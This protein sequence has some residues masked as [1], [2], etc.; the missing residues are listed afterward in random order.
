[1]AEAGLVGI[2]LP[3]ADGGSGFGVVELCLVAE[4]VGR[5]VAPVPYVVAAC[6][7]RLVAA[8]G[9]DAQRAE[10]L[11]A[12]ATGDALLVPAVAEPGTY[13]PPTVPVAT[14]AAPEGDG[15]RLDGEKLFV[16]WADRAHRLLVP[17]RLPD[18]GVGVALV[19]PT[20]PGV[21]L[22][23]LTTTSGLPEHDVRLTGVAVGGDALLGGAGADG[24]AAVRRLLDELAVATCAVQSGVSAEALR[25]TAAYTSERKQFDTPIATFQAVAQR[26]ADAYID[27]QGVRF[28][29]LQAAWRLDEGLP[30]ADEVDIATFWAADGGQRVANA[31]QH[32]H[33][34]IGVDTDYPLHRYFLWAKH[35]ELAHGGA[36]EHLRRLGARLAAEPA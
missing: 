6:G 2:C 4:E 13:A 7:A 31:A 35:L 16:P 28:T 17:A 32:L 21:A 27:A 36:T 18:G 15:W 9:T 30:A 11:P 1:M 8:L 29:M 3:E 5:R 10:L 12:A 20:A 23:A 19:D 26:A 24:E 25:M 14:T 22:E 34:G 33:G